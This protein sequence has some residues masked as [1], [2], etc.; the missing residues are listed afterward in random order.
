[1]NLLRRASCVVRQNG[2]QPSIRARFVLNCLIGCIALGAASACT[3][4]G[5]SPSTPVA[6]A[7]DTLPSPSVVYGDT[8]R[9]I[10]GLAAKLTG[11]AYNSDGRE[12]LDA[13]IQYF[14]SDATAAT[15]SSDRY[16]IA[17]TDTVKKSF[18]IRAQVAGIPSQLARTLDLTWRP[19]SVDR[20][21]VAIDRED[22]LYYAAADSVKLLDAS[23]SVRVIS[24][25]VPDTTKPDTVTRLVKSFLVK[26]RILAPVGADSAKADSLLTNENSQRSTVDTTNAEGVAAR[27]IRF[28]QSG[29]L[30][31]VPDSVV[32]EATVRY[33]GA[34]VPGAPIR[35][36]VRVRQTS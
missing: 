33:R 29:G 17:T 19:D 8:L 32:V 28:F 7:F 35:F 18:T 3:D 14:L 6:L 9:G 12:I 36:K 16:L 23:L 25:F 5:T 26:F 27:K 22:T 10:N 20:G 30:T 31:A 2:S 15:V 4:V 34:S 1:L 11:H 13:P 24:R 21:T